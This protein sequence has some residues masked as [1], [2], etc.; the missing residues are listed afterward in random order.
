MTYIPKLDDEVEVTLRGRV[1]S[2]DNT[3]HF[4][5]IFDEDI[6]NSTLTLG[7]GDVNEFKVT[8]T[9]KVF[10]VGTIVRSTEDYHADLFV[11]GVEGYM[12]L[13]RGV[14]FNHPDYKF[15]SDNWEEVVL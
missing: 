11:V 2:V 4:D 7:V 5:V 15:T 9:I 10:P 14:W 3:G 1:D 13:K 12:N 8:K 6:D